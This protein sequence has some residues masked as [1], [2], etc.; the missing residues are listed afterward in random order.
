MF[1]RIRIPPAIGMQVL[2]ASVYGISCVWLLHVC[3]F[4]EDGH[5]KASGCG[6][7][8]RYGSHAFL[9]PPES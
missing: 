4:N 7:G 3:P 5:A 1:M 9:F 8:K 2:T 6:T